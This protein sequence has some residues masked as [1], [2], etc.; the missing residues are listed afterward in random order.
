MTN[1]EVTLLTGR[2]MPSIGLGTWELTDNTAT[3]VATAL[4]M[5]YQMIDTSGD[6]GT[7]PA[8]GQG[9]AKSG[10]ER[11]KVYIVTKVEETGNAYATV[12]HNLKELDLDYADLILIHRPP[13]NNT[14]EEIWRELIHAREEG[15]TKDIGVSNYSE[16][17]IQS[18]FVATKVMPVVNQIEWSPWGWSQHMLDFC[19]DNNIVVQGYSPLTRGERLGETV[20]TT[21]GQRYDKTPA[22]IVL[23]WVQQL[24]VIPIVKAGQLLHL[25][26]NLELDFTLSDADVI[27]LCSLNDTYSALG[28]K[29]AYQRYE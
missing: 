12:V 14:S 7:Q 28:D 17:Q 21:I 27:Q 8:V 15:V 16:D 11:D 3:V 29:P 10:I 20:L 25:E 22:Q 24:G 5:G 6:Y 23:R 9:L 13:A 26:E 4:Q 1:Y 2:T 18:L 19:H